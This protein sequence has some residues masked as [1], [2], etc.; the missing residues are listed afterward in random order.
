[1][2]SS[3]TCNTPIGY[4]FLVATNWLGGYILL[5]QESNKQILIIQEIADVR[6]IVTNPGC[7]V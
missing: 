2:L 5:I 1:M 7:G 3:S 6:D 4:S